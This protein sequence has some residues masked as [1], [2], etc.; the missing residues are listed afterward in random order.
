MNATNMYQIRKINPLLL[1]FVFVVV[2]LS[3]LFLARLVFKLLFYIAPILF[4][5]AL[6]INYRV[7][8][9]YGKWLISTFKRSVPFGLLATL[10]TIVGAPLVSLFL[11][12]RALTSRG[13]GVPGVDKIGYTDYEV[14]EEEEFLDLTE[15]RE[16]RKRIDRDYRDIMG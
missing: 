11:F 3:F 14:V 2:I 12:L 5:G 7:V 6:L 1:L 9:G 13:Y 15:V 8:L 4:I 16:R 10:F